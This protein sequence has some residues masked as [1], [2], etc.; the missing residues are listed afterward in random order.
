MSAITNI[1]VHWAV[2][3]HHSAWDEPIANTEFFGTEAEAREFGESLI[4]RRGYSR[5]DVEVCVDVLECT[6][7]DRAYAAIYYGVSKSGDY[8]DEL[9]IARL[10]M[11]SDEYPEYDAPMSSLDTELEAAGFIVEPSFTEDIDEPGEPTD[12]E[13][14]PDTWEEMERLFCQLVDEFGDLLDDAYGDE[15][16]KLVS[17]FPYD[18]LRRFD[19]AMYLVGK[20]MDGKRL[21]RLKASA[22]C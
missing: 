17:N 10:E 5:S 21:A 14:A 8:E 6:I 4:D 7:E 3:I 12:Q 13:P 20:A 16:G 22:C 15:W 9:R 19:M 18:P 11:E 2:A 1:S